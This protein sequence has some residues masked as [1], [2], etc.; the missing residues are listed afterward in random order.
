M[1][2]P[3]WQLV[4]AQKIEQVHMPMSHSCSFIRQIFIEHHS[5]PSTLLGFS[6]ESGILPSK[7]LFLFLEVGS[8]V[9][10]ISNDH[11]LKYLFVEY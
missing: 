3:C 1:D 6:S 5:M 4:R 11:F 2:M 10:D 8:W 9:G 7:S